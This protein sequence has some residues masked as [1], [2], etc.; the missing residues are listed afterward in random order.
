MAPSYYGAT[1]PAARPWFFVSGRYV[2]FS[3]A[4]HSGVRDLPFETPAP[5]GATSRYGLRVTNIYRIVMRG[6]TPSKIQLVAHYTAPTPFPASA[7]ETTP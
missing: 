3:A 5:V 4:L 7:F 6:R 1:F 2:I